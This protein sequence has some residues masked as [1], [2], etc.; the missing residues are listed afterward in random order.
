MN[1]PDLDLDLRVL[2]Y[3]SQCCKISVIS[4]PKAL[5]TLKST[6]NNMCNTGTA[7]AVKRLHR[8]GYIATAC[9]GRPRAPVRFVLTD[10]GAEM[11]A[12]RVAA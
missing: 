1:T 8:G 7:D 4:G 11:L 9:S 10:K 2:R 5:A 3:V 12:Q 6:R